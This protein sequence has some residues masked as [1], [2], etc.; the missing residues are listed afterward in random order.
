MVNRTRRDQV[1]IVPLRRNPEWTAL[2]FFAGIGLARAG[3]E[4]AGVKTVWANDYDVHKKTMY[5]GNG[6]LVSLFSLIYTL[7]MAM[8]S[9]P[10]MLHGHH[11]HAQISA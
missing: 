10:P 8:S 6:V 11:L 1:N 9:L 3:L 4:L 5:E 2:E 7:S